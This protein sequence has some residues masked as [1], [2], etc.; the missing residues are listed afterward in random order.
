MSQKVIIKE[1]SSYGNVWL[2]PV[3]EVAILLTKLTGKKTLSKIDLETINQLGYEL[4]I[5]R[6]P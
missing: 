2:K 1:H 6:I 5:Q 3:N 4:E